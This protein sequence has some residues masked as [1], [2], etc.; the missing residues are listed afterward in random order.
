MG[1]R[2]TRLSAATLPLI[3]ALPCSAQEVRPS[4]L[5]GCYDLEMPR[6]EGERESI[7]SVFYRPPPRVRLVFDSTA[8]EGASH[9][10]EVPAGALPSPHP[11]DWTSWNPE[12]GAVHVTWSTGSIG[13]GA[14]LEAV[15]GSLEGEV[16]IFTDEMGPGNPPRTALRARRVDCDTPP[17]ARLTASDSLLREFPLDSGERLVLAEPLPDVEVARRSWRPP[18]HPV[19][20]AER[21]A[22]PLGPTEAVEV[23]L[24]RSGVLRTL[25]LTFPEDREWEELSGLLRDRFGSPH[26]SRRSDPGWRECIWQTRI[27]FLRLFRDGD[28]R[29]TL[30]GRGL[31]VPRLER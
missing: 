13:I 31:R 15:D 28:G 27:S 11:P 6:W 4:E 24:T 26:L 3:V 23:R 1:E 16:G 5:A 7:D 19:E 10:V 14:E 22:V 2:L 25:E 21:V 30:T 17:P 8:S 18:N 20:L 12:G 9:P 29:I